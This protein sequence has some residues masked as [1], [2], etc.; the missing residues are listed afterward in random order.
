MREKVLQNGNGVRIF[1]V[2]GVTCV[3]TLDR[4][5][6]VL[7]TQAFLH[8]SPYLLALRHHHLARSINLHHRTHSSQL[9]PPLS[10]SGAAVLCC[11]AGGS[12]QCKEN[13]GRSRKE[14]QPAP[15]QHSQHSSPST[16]STRCTHARKL[17]YP[18]PALLFGL[19]PSVEIRYVVGVY[20][21][22][23]PECCYPLD[24]SGIRPFRKVLS[25]AVGAF[26]TRVLLLS[27][28]VHFR[29]AAVDLS[30]QSIV[31]VYCLP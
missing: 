4:R 11:P 1:A 31:V 27:V 26:R 2:C 3:A 5:V 30:P 21:A 8:F 25:S 15:T 17:T 6:E 28:P 29:R 24:N 19:W 7:L 10:G 9:S 20:I 12:A 14:E 13:L 16:S 22:L 23:T 18:L